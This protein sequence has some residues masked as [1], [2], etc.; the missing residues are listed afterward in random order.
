MLCGR[1]LRRVLARSLSRIALRAGLVFSTCA[2]AFFALPLLHWAC[3]GSS[4]DALESDFEAGFAAL[5][6]AN[7]VASVF[8]FFELGKDVFRVAYRELGM[9]SVV[10]GCIS[11]RFGGVFCRVAYRELRCERVV[12]LAV[13]KQ[14]NSR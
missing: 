2:C 8:A 4:L 1:V 10:F 7:C 9:F 6:I 11:V 3:L 5:L 13:R 12:C 14:R